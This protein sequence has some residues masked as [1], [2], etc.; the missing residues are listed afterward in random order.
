MMPKCWVYRILKLEKRAEFVRYIFPICFSIHYSG[1][2][3][4]FN[5]KM[6]YR[7]CMRKMQLNAFVMEMFGKGAK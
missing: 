1:S 4:I 2:L 6:L 3:R 5:Y 7:N